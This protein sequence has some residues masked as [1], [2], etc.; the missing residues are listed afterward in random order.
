MVWSIIYLLFEE[1]IVEVRSVTTCGICRRGYSLQASLVRTS[2]PQHPSWSNFSNRTSPELPA[3]MS[4]SKSESLLALQRGGCIYNLHILL[5]PISFLKPRSLPHTHTLCFE[6]TA[7]HLPQH[8]S[9]VA[10]KPRKVE[11]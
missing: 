7:K 3:I 1:N 4:N 11:E 5:I 9:R 8:P 6:P 10:Y 2:T